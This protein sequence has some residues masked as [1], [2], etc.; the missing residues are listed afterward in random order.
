[1]RR[2]SRVTARS[3]NDYDVMSGRWVLCILVL[4]YIFH[5]ILL[6]LGCFWIIIHLNLYTHTAHRHIHMIQIAN[7]PYRKIYSFS[8]TSDAMILK[9]VLYALALLLPFFMVYSTNSCLYTL[10]RF[11]FKLYWQYHHQCDHCVW[12]SLLSHHWDI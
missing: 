5:I 12:L 1:M 2:M 8:Y 9:I 7:V 10:C 3:M 6:I 11:L 4:N